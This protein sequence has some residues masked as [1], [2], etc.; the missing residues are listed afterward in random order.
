MARVV[1]VVVSL[2]EGPAFRRLITFVR[3]VEELAEATDDGALAEL[4][5][6][7]RDDLLAL[8]DE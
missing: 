5:D 4:V 1:P 2:T 7:L 8:R 6:N 3:E